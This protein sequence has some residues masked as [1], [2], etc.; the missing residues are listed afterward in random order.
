MGGGGT[1]RGTPPP[2]VRHWHVVILLGM[3]MVVGV[4]MAEGCAWQGHAWQGGMCG[5]G[6]MHGREVCVARPTHAPL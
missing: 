2:F 6:G 5:K 3:C 1:R 4:C